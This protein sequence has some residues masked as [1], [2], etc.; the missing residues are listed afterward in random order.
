MA[1]L[2]LIVDDPRP[3]MGEGRVILVRMAGNLSNHP[4]VL[5][6]GAG[7]ETS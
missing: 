4:E 3:T 6:G 1:T 2:F 5:K 7:F